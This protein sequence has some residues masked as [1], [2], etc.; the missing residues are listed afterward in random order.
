MAAR[1][2]ATAHELTTSESMSLLARNGVGRLAYSL[3]DRVDIVPI[4]YVV[5]GVWIY[6]RTGLGAKLTS[7]A[8]HRWCA[9]ETDEVRGPM[10]WESV[11][12][13]GSFHLLDPEVAS[14]EAY[15]HALRLARELLPQALTADD[16]HPDRT[17]LF[18]IHIDTI[19]GRSMRAAPDTSRVRHRSA[20]DASASRAIAVARGTET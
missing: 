12:V 10:D 13:K 18:R 20:A 11:V 15:E 6:G 14:D 8:H 16:P 9:L 2:I 7:L 19:T 17:L 3:H 4:N 5:D 1:Q